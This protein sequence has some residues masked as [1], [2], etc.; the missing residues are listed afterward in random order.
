MSVEDL[1]RMRGLVQLLV[2]LVTRSA[3]GIKLLVNLVTCTANGIEHNY[4]TRADA[5]SD[6]PARAGAPMRAT[7]TPCSLSDLVTC[8]CTHT[9]SI[10]GLDRLLPFR[11][12]YLR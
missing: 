4:V 9:H 1:R 10:R 6:R 11:S 7:W 3:H 12:S 8:G 5:V 2:N